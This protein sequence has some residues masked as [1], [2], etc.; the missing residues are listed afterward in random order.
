ME[1]NKNHKMI[2]EWKKVYEN[3][4]KSSYPDTSRKEI[5]MFLDKIIDDNI[6]V[7]KAIVDNNYVHKSIQVDLLTLI[8]WIYDK[9]LI[10]GGHA[11]FFKNRHEAPNPAAMMLETFLANRKAI[12][13]KLKDL[14]PGSYE[15]AV[16]DR[17]QLIEKLAANSYYGAGGAPTSNFFNS[18]H[19]EYSGFF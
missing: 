17:N 10:C 1:V 19:F 12:K 18:D 4:L 6:E 14:E 8:D 15:Y 13:K 11:V 5:S 2:K 9:K 3:I 16:C 7:P